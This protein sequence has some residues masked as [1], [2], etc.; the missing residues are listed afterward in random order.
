M[1]LSAA[2]VAIFQQIKPSN[3]EIQD[4][5]RARESAAA[6]IWAKAVERSRTAQDN[7]LGPEKATERNMFECCS[8]FDVSV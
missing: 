4:E 6:R 8:C 1:R 5:L 2:L 7:L 3:L